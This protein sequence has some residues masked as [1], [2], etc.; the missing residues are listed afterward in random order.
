MNKLAEQ[1]TGGDIGPISDLWESLTA[2]NNDIDPMDLFC[3]IKRAETFLEDWRRNL[4]KKANKTFKGLLDDDV[5]RKEWSWGTIA[6]L[7]RY[8]PAGTWAYPKE[9][10]DIEYQLKQARV[11][12]Q[13]S[14]AAIKTVPLPSDSIPL[15][16]VK[17][18]SP[19]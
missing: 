13:Q 16:S 10:T 1:I 7:T 9:V 5:T 18:V 17:L 12:A 15:F 14:G 2:D 6:T 3:Q 8:T 19:P 11:K 4:T